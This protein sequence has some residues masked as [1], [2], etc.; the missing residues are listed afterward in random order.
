MREQR[1]PDRI[2][3]STDWPPH[4]KQGRVASR[5]IKMCLLKDSPE[6]AYWIKMKPFTVDELST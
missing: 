1:K 4:A 2:E 3:Q 5:F 6:I